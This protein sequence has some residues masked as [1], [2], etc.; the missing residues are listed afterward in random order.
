M[1]YLII[2][3]GNSLSAKLTNQ[4]ARTNY[5]TFIAGLKIEESMADCTDSS[6]NYYPAIL[7]IQNKES[8]HR[9]I[10]SIKPN[11]IIN[12]IGGGKYIGFQDLTETQFLETIRLNLTSAHMIT[13]AFHSYLTTY[14]LKGAAIVHTSSINSIN[15]EK[16]YIHYSVAKTAL[17]S[18]IRGAAIEISPWLRIGG[19]RL[20]PVET[21]DNSLV[22]LLKNNSANYNLI[23][24]RLTNGCDL[25]NVCIAF[26]QYLTWIT[27]ETITADGGLLLG[28]TKS[29]N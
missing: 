27:G 25:A 16:G 29:I 6:A 22:A 19:V 4:L 2:G 3:S 18:Y 10:T 20:G 26:C 17:E 5:Q 21:M 8:I 9:A 14:R 24:H 7:D 13:L 28:N 23:E 15:P 11:F 12:L 1:R